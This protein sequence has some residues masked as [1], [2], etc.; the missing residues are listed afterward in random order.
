MIIRWLTLPVITL[1]AAVAGAGC[2]AFLGN[3]Y[4]NAKDQIAALK[5]KDVKTQAAPSLSKLTVD[6]IAIMSIVNDAPKN[7]APL[8]AGAS[9]AITAELY[10]QAAIAGGW[11]VVPRTT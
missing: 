4:D 3:Q 6:R 2:T 7:G 9:D 11:Q 10:S 5:P 8:S 1:I